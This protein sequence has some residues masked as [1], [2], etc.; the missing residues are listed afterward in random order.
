MKPSRVT[1]LPARKRL[2][3]SQIQSSALAPQRARFKRSGAH[4]AMLAALVVC[5]VWSLKI[6]V[7]QAAD[8]QRIKQDG[9]QLEQQL[10]QVKTQHT[11]LEREKELMNSPTYIEGIARERLGMIKQGETPFTAKTPAGN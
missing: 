3:N 7:A 11:A 8:L 4:L 10:E 6:F 1:K 5:G 9:Q 2:P